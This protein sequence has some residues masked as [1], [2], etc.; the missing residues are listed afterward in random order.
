MMFLW[1]NRNVISQHFGTNSKEIKTLEAKFPPK[2]S[3]HF[4]NFTILGHLYG[5]QTLKK[6]SQSEIPK[7]PS[8]PKT[9]E[10]TGMIKEQALESTH[11]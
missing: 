4:F 1:S 11:Y 3:G 6:L 9:W 8:H 7:R 2:L 5:H 10:W